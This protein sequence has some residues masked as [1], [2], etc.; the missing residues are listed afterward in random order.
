MTR[1]ETF[2]KIAIELQRANGARRQGTEGRVRACARREAGH[3]L[4]WWL[5]RHPGPGGPRSAL[6]RLRKESGEET[7]PP[8]VRE[9]AWLLT[10]RV[11]PKPDA[12]ALF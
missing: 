1:V 11:S 8:H 3:A 6:D 7:F 2:D 10:L 9:A 5:E 4:N 12:G